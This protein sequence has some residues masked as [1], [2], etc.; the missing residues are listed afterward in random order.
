MKA[1]MDQV[2]AEAL[3]IRRA[4]KALERSVE[5]IEEKGKKIEKLNR[6]I[7]EAEYAVRA[8]EIVAADALDNWTEALI[9]LKK[10]FSAQPRFKEQPS[11]VINSA[12][13][14]EILPDLHEVE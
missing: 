3:R 6:D 8:S 13:S 2:N 12:F 7:E 1:L 9:Q 4:K 5:E 14:D 11:E 10:S